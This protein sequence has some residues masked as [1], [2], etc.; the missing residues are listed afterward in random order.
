[1]IRTNAPSGS[2]RIPYSVSP[3]RKLNNRGPM[4]MKNWVTFIPVSRAVTKCPSSWRKIDT[5][6]PSTN[7]SAH[8]LYAPRSTSRATMP[9]NDSQ[10]CRPPAVFA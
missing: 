8:L 3:R 2:R 7:T 9:A 1:M 6:R 5:S 10:P 4:K